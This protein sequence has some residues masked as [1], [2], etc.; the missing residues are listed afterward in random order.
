VDLNVAGRR[1]SEIRVIVLQHFRT[2]MTVNAGGG[3]FHERMLSVLDRFANCAHT[4]S[5]LK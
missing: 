5:M 4:K 2:V 3:G 1:I